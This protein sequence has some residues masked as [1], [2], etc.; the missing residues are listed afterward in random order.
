MNCGDIEA[1]TGV[2]D[3]ISEAMM[4]MLRNAVD[5]GIEAPEARAAAGKDR[6]GTI[7]FNVE[8]TVGELIVS[9]EDDGCGIDE[10][11]L[12]E[13]KSE[14]Q[15]YLTPG[16]IGKI[17]LANLYSR[18]QILYQGKASLEIESSPHHGTAVTL[19]L[20]ATT[21]LTELPH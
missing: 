14:F 15:N 17:G 8:S 20:P 5:H 3:I 12:Q 4:H 21:M 6:K 18:L 16:H 9:L 2:V 10:A 7:T 19:L 11:H 1:D 13:L